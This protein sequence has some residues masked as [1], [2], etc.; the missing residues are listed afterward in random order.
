MEM[1]S[2]MMPDYIHPRDGIGE[3]AARAQCAEWISGWMEKGGTSNPN[4]DGLTLREHTLQAGWDDGRLQLFGVSGFTMNDGYAV[5]QD[6]KLLTILP[7]MGVMSAWLSDQDA[8]GH[9][10][11]YINAGFGSGMINEE[12]HCYDPQTGKTWHLAERG[13]RDFILFHRE[14]R[15][16]VRVIPY[17]SPRPDPHRNNEFR[18]LVLDGEGMSLGAEVSM[19]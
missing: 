8:D 3:D 15:L 11:F 13:K 10:E 4:L 17:T 7:G 12:I 2:S 19:P 6:G 14:G 16:V 18:E 5:F 1:I 9:Y